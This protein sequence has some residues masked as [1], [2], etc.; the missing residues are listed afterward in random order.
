MLRILQKGNLKLK[1]LIK[2]PLLIFGIVFLIVFSA[3]VLRSVA[4][5]FF[6]TYWIYLVLA[7]I[8]FVFFSSLDFSVVNAFAKPLYIFSIVFLILPL[9]IGEVTRGAIRWIPIGTLTIQPAEIVKPF[10]ILFWA[11]HLKGFTFNFGKVLRLLFFLVLPLVLIL[12]Q[13]S[14]GVTVLTFMGFVGVFLATGMNKRLYLFFVFVA[15]FALG[16]GW[17][18]LAPYQRQRV[19]TFI[20]PQADPSGAGYNSLQSMIAVGSGKLTGRGIGEG[21]QTQLYFLP[22]RHNDF[23]FASI[24]EELGFLGAS[25][26]LVGIFFLLWRIVA[27]VDN[28]VDPTARAFLAGVFLT[29]FTQTVVHIGMNMGLL[30][31]TGVP[32]PLV[33][34]G[35]SSLLATMTMLGM[36]IS[37]RK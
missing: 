9:L 15:I 16:M 23:I 7:V 2:D 32:L 20:S 6:P 26:V 31:I 29:L 24:A 8:S 1:K 5:D 10:L 35:G 3:I 34:A 37:A 13:P 36:V 19:T 25:L 27:A 33:S 14:L 4:S 30:P 17:F 22:E 18:F 21:V 12:L 28:P 11:T